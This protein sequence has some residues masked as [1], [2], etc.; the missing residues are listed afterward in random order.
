M[1]GE[2]KGEDDVRS[3]REQNTWF[4]I[5][6]TKYIFLQIGAKKGKGEILFKLWQKKTVL[7]PQQIPTE[8][9]ISQMLQIQHTGRPENPCGTPL[10]GSHVELFTIT[11]AL[12]KGICRAL[13]LLTSKF[14]VPSTAGCQS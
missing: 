1:F 13:T 8:M 10:T 5:S 2:K 6:C 9:F 14:V 11:G 12:Y 7:K 4:Y 3:R